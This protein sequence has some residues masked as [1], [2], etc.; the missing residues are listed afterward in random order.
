MK[1]FKD[2]K[3]DPIGKIA[4]L[5]DERAIWIIMVVAMG[6]LVVVAHSLFQNYIY[7]APC[8]QCV[9]I[10]FSMLVMA[11]GGVIAAI[12]PKNIILKII[13]YIFGFYG[14]IIG[15]MYSLKL[16]SIHNAVHS[17][18]PFGVQ[19]CSFEPSFPFGLRLDIWVPGLFKP[20]GDCGYDNP[21]VPYGV[22]LSWLRQWFVDFYSEG[23]YLIP[24]LKFINMAQACFIA[25]AV[26]FV[27]LCAMLVCQ[28]VKSKKA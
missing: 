5:Q 8:E 11:L 10:R 13:G 21:M 19:G 18:D 17:E 9:Y 23:W 15:M 27:L 7:M 1:F 22:S 6:G 16:N 2:L 24:S 25:Y 26:A 4:S 12:N 14:A 28:I 20:T 3:S